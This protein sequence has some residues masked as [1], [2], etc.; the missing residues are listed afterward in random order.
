VRQ[1]PP[2]SASTFPTPPSGVIGVQAFPFEISV[3]TTSGSVG[4]NGNEVVVSSP[5]YGA[6]VPSSDWGNL[7]IG[8]GNF[9]NFFKSKVICVSTTVINTF[10]S[11]NN[12][13]TNT[14]LV[15]CCYSTNFIIPIRFR[16]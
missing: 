16:S 14:T 9:H 5:R 7:P 10:K 3:T 8:D 2:I 12:R 13:V 6:V 4:S 15:N 11:N 1:L